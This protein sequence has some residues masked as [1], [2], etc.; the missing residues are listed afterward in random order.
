MEQFGV[1]SVAQV[2][3]MLAQGQAMLLDIR[4]AQSYAAGHVPGRFI[5]PMPRWHN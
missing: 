3:Q 2:Q 5:S 4:D 1:I